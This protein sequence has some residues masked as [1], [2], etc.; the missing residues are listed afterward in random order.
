MFRIRYRFRTICIAD[1][2]TVGWLI[3]PAQCLLRCRVILYSHGDDLAERPGEE[4]L[5][6]RRRGQ[7]AIADAIVAV[8]EAAA[9]ELGR[10]F[11]VPRARVTVVPNGVDTAL[12]RPLPPD[13]TL[14]ELLG[15]GGRRVIATVA[16]LVARKGVDQV[17]E[18]ISRL[19]ADFP[20]LHYLVVGDGP[21]RDRLEH[22]AKDRNVADR[23]SF[24]G[25]VPTTDVPRYLALAELV[26]IPNRLENDAPARL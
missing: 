26:S 17:I 18:S 4:A 25:S 8:S 14:I 20:D 13:P 22:L 10:V 24:T 11:G 6:A 12:Y 5:L 19:W 3:R 21:E 23:I 9:R 2:E 7:F 16:R 1:D 15:L